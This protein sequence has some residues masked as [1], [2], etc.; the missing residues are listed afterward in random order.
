M[1]IHFGLKK[2]IFLIR[3]RGTKYTCPFCGYKSDELGPFGHE[4]EIIN[5]LHVV[6]GGRRNVA[7]LKCGAH[8]RERLIYV[9]IK[10][11]AKIFD[12]P[13]LSLLHIAPEPRISKEILKHRNI[14]YICGDL[15]TP[16]YEY[17][18]YVQNI[19]VL[20]IPYEDNHFDIVLCNHVL[21]HIPEDTE[22]MREIYRVLKPDGFAILQVPISYQ[23][24]KTIEDFSITDP[25]ERF[26]RF[27]QRDHC[28]LYGKDYEDRLMGVG[29]K[30]D[31]ANIGI[32]FSQ[33]ALNLEEK[34]FICKK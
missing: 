25:E 28:R 8:D 1:K 12:A 5:R 16:G 7:C 13:H 15:F 10:Y 32:H 23:L 14:E 19:N 33:Y 4:S 26:L 34:L 2:R 21:E 18:S 30:V 17:P 9:Y 11:V 31:Q 22:A 6:G 20:H 24:E 3:H 27:G 29:F